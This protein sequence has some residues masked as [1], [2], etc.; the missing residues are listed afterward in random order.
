MEEHV[1]PHIATTTTESPTS[2]SPYVGWTDVHSP[3]YAP[4]IKCKKYK[5]EAL[6]WAV[7]YN[8]LVDFYNKNGHSNVK[9][10][11]PDTKLAGWVKRQRNNR[12]KKKLS[13]KQIHLLDLLGFTWNRIDA[14]WEVKYA[15]LREYQRKTGS[16]QV[17]AG[18]SSKGDRSLAEWVQR[19]KREYRNKAPSSTPIRASRLESIPGWTWDSGAATTH[20]TAAHDDEET[21]TETEEEE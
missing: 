15:W 5:N 9:R 20:T 8:T 19:Q 4:G 1:R 6:S 12:V 14:A 2:T 21:E 18:G 7:S 16:C 11:D 3:G 17:G 13:E 10:S